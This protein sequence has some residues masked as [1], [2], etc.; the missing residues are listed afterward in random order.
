MPRAA[1]GLPTT[2]ARET[3]TNVQALHGPL[4]RGGRNLFQDRRPAFSFELGLGAVVRQSADFLEGA[5]S[6]LPFVQR[7]WP[8]ADA[9]AKGPDD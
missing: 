3:R 8:L 4:H 1:L 5:W 9:T 2:R 6:E 7:I